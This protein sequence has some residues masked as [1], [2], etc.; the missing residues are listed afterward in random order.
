MK[1][2]LKKFRSIKPYSITISDSSLKRLRFNL[3]DTN[4][5]K[6]CLKLYFKMRKLN[7]FSPN[8]FLP[9]VNLSF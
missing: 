2:G 8:K 9:E 7:I 4:P 1:V 5:G 3:T 6:N